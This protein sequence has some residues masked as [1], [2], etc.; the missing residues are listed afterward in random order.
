MEIGN[1]EQTARERTQQTRT[2]DPS[3][4][5]T[6]RQRQKVGE[7]GA[8]HPRGG[9]FLIRPINQV[10]ERAHDSTHATTDQAKSIP[11]RIGATKERLSIPFSDHPRVVELVPPKAGALPTERA[12]GQVPGGTI[13]Q[14]QPPFGERR[15]ERQQSGHRVRLA[16]P[17]DERFPEHHVPPALAVDHRTKCR[18]GAKPLQEPPGRRKPPR[19]QLRVTT[20]Q[21]HRIRRC[22]AGASSASGEKGKTSAP[23]LRHPSSTCGYE[24][25]NASSRANAIR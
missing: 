20:R 2:D 11:A 23:A 1:G 16:V 17:V 25:A 9:V 15:L 21:I 13:A 18:R 3:P 10:H 22:R 14:G 19:M 12:I 24:N 8:L 5:R 7:I 6:R 4:R